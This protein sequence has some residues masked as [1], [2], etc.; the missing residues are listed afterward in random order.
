MEIR[1]FSAYLIKEVQVQIN[2]LEDDFPKHFVDDVVL[3]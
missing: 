3:S 2:I 1:S